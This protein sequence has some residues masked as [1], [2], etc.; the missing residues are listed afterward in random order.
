[1]LFMLCTSAFY[2]FHKCCATP[3]GLLFCTD[4]LS[5]E[6]QP[7]VGD[8][9]CSWKSRLMPTSKKS[10]NKAVDL[11]RPASFKTCSKCC[12]ERTFVFESK[13]NDNHMSSMYFLCEFYTCDRFSWKSVCWCFALFESILRMKR[14]VLNANFWFIVDNFVLYK[15]HS[16]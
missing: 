16:S 7:D 13:W 5:V 1:M 15:C 8:A 12:V 6:S 3:W 11:H 10:F 14:V 2:I 9:E 4:L